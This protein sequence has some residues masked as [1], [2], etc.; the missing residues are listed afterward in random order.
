VLGYRGSVI[1]KAKTGYIVYANDKIVVI[2]IDETTRTEYS[3]DGYSKCDTIGKYYGGDFSCRTINDK[4]NAQEILLFKNG[5][6]ERLYPVT[7]EIISLSAFNDI[8]YYLTKYGNLNCISNNE[9]KTIANNIEEYALNSLGEL[10]YIQENDDNEDYDIESDMD[11]MLYYSVN[12]KTKKLGEANSV[13]WLSNNELLVNAE[14]VA[15]KTDADDN[16]VSASHTYDDYIVTVDDNQWTYSKKFNKIP[17]IV[18][19]SSDGKKAI[20]EICD[21]SLTYLYFGIYD[22]EKDIFSKK[23]IHDGIKNEDV[24]GEMYFDMGTLWLDENPMK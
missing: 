19:V 5:S 8:V 12:G 10:A 11:G 9:T 22:I 18:D 7:E 20:T 14:N 24:F 21:S 4:T 6:V 23:A 13:I 3:I 2:D 1:A 17:F 16:V 15:V